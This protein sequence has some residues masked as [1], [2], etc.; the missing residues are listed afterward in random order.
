MKPE[1]TAKIKTWAKRLGFW[2]I[3]FFTIKGLAWLA[4]GYFVLK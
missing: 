1:T 4:L 2:G 3:L